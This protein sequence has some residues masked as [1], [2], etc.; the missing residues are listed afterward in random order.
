[1]VTPTG[2]EPVLPPLVPNARI[3]LAPPRKS[4]GASGATITLI[5]RKGGVLAA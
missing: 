4:I 2:I 5:Q 1:M 3:A